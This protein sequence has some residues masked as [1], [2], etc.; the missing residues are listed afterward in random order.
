M[1]FEQACTIKSLIATS[2]NFRRDGL[3]KTI[4]RVQETIKPW[5]IEMLTDEAARRMRDKILLLK[6]QENDSK[7]RNTQGEII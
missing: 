4:Q 7:N 5:T 2:D 6:K 3:E 1:T